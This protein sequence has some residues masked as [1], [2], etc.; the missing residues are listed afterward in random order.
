MGNR[1]IAR[2]DQ[3]VAEIYRVIADANG[4]VAVS[5]YV[6]AEMDGRFTGSY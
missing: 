3:S 2:F 4:A 1:M 6:G 5:D